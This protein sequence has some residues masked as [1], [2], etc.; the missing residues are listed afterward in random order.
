MQYSNTVLYRT[1]FTAY[2]HI[3]LP[4]SREW[5]LARVA[6]YRGAHS[7]NIIGNS[8]SWAPSEGGAMYTGVILGL[9]CIYAWSIAAI[10]SEDTKHRMVE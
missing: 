4:N 3:C 1:L 6:L 10:S 7:V 5:R 9:E 2:G 8:C